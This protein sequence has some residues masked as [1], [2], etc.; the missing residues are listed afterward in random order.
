MIHP[1]G[2]S[3]RT[4]Y[5]AVFP[6]AENVVSWSKILLYRHAHIVKFR[7]VW[8]VHF[9]KEKVC[10][11]RYSYLEC[12]EWRLLCVAVCL[13]RLSFLVLSWGNIGVIFLYRNT[14]LWSQKSPW[15][16]NIILRRSCRKIY[17]PYSHLH[18]LLIYSC[19]IVNLVV[20][21]GIW[22]GEWDSMWWKDP[23]YFENLKRNTPHTW[24]S[25]S[26]RKRAHKAR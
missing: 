21:S 16:L 15:T 12:N 11:S 5:K 9:A 20:L 18:T 14:R 13:I 8:F 23:L 25:N 6:G 10:F 24:G 1:K 7:A 26:L 17:D 4:G 2:N 3:T 22:N 19:P